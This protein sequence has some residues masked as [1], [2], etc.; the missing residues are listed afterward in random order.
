MEGYFLRQTPE[1]N[2]KGR[3]L[4]EIFCVTF[5]AVSGIFFV[6][7]AGRAHGAW[8]R[9]SP[10]IRNQKPEVRFGARARDR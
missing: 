4:S 2:G 7:L 1:K 10:E 6:M 9:Q 5:S 3:K 8:R